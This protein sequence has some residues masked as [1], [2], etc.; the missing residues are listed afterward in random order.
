ML[1]ADQRPEPCPEGV[2]SLITS[3]RNCVRGVAMRVTLMK[4]LALDSFYCYIET[5]YF[6]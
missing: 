3:Q 5:K 4:Y 6:V 1:R 2:I